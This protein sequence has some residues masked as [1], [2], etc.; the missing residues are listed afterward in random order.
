MVSLPLFLSKISLQ[1]GSLFPPSPP[2]VLIDKSD[3]PLLS[4]PTTVILLAF[5]LPVWHI[6]PPFPFRSSIAL[7]IQALLY[8]S[9]VTSKII[10]PSPLLIVGGLAHFFWFK[11]LD[12]LLYNAPAEWSPGFQER[13]EKNSKPERYSKWRKVEWAFRISFLTRGLGL[14]YAPAKY[15]SLREINRNLSRAQFLRRRALN[16]LLTYAALDLISGYNSAY[17][18]YRAETELP[19][20]FLARL[21]FCIIIWTGFSQFISLWYLIWTTLMV[22]MNLSTPE[23]CPPLFGH[24]SDVTSVRRFWGR[25]WHPLFYRAFYCHGEFICRALHIS[26]DTTLGRSIVRFCAFLCSGLTHGIGM[27][28]GA[29]MDNGWIFIMLQQFAV[30]ELEDFI[31]WIYVRFLGRGRGPAKTWEKVLGALWGWGWIVFSAMLWFEADWKG[32]WKQT[33]TFPL[34]SEAWW[35]QMMKA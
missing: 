35:M 8:W 25:F 26:E 5:L 29:G 12:L 31:K 20:S 23:F 11:S 4:A 3:S 34:L 15:E 18:T 21:R 30:I 14:N 16:L 32:G 7:P 22:A 9:I 27:A 33:R 6:L 2:L 13:H 28:M 10:V 17:I 19:A 1:P 24:W